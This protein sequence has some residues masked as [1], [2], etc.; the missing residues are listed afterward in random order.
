MSSARADRVSHPKDPTSLP[1]RA[2]GASHA[3]F[4]GRVGVLAA[5]LGVGTLIGGLGIAAADSGT[6][7]TTSAQSDSGT[8]AK[9]GAQTSGRGERRT[10]PAPVAPAAAAATERP[11]PAP[12]VTGSSTDTRASGDSRGS[13][14]RPGAV[15]SGRA[16]RPALPATGA[17]DLPRLPDIGR[18]VLTA[19]PTAPVA[20][21]D[22][23][24]VSAAPAGTPTPAAPEQVAVDAV[25]NP[26]L[27]GGPGAPG[28][29]A[30]AWA[31]L[32]AARRTGRVSAA[33]ATAQPLPAATTTTGTT[34]KITWAWGSNTALN[35][36]TAT[37]KLDFGWFAPTEFSVSENSGSTRISITNNNQTYTLTGVG[38]KQLSATTNIIALN[39][40]TAA[41]WQNAIATASS[42]ATSTPSTPTTPTSP[43]VSG[44]T[45][46]KIIWAWG[47]NTALNFNPATDKLDFGW[48][49][50]TN[51]EIAEPGGSTQISITGNNQT[52][53]L[54]GVGLKQMSTGNIIALDPATTAKWQNAITNAG[55]V[56]PPPVVS[57]PTVSIS[58]VSVAEGNSGSTTARF[59]VSLSK[60]ATST[61][62]VGYATANGTATAG[63]DYTATSGT[64]SFAPGV[65]SQQISVNVTGDTTV[66][67]DETF[68]VTLANP[69]GA[70][71][72][73]ASA[74][75][76]ITNDD[77]A[78]VVSA[79]TLSIANVSVA[80]GN[81]GSTTARFTVS[82]SKAATSTVTVGYA[83]AN[84]TATAGQDYTAA[85][86]TL[87]FTPGVISQQISVN[88]TGDT[89]V[90]PTETF[91]VTLTNPTGATF[92]S[93]AAT[94]SATGTITNDDTATTPVTPPVVG[95]RWGTTFYAPY[96]DMGGWPVP[97]LLAISQ[98]NGGG[99]LFTAAFMQATP[100][101]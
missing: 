6:D 51:F 44:G 77:T 32:A 5:A 23:P 30:L 27:G 99:S 13:D 82:L 87:S 49:Q 94:A 66:E 11:A 70:T 74:T 53:T 2:P 14:S 9:A 45:I 43:A 39:P 78:P 22:A 26:L 80:E 59:T 95:D 93:G 91:T 86:G 54:S 97:D 90:E 68:T 85:S 12:R 47:T 61:V 67:P 58:N 52:Y 41:K 62:T 35:F 31:V 16:V 21:G 17:A 92:V 72:A 101:G 84:G 15:T 25:V 71:L 88:V 83:T 38:L 50:P 55:T 36:N 96:V 42:T 56:T 76:T 33:S 48:F 18:P 46:T 81:S 10:A 69:T 65:I 8:N 64:V 63:Q 57:A 20:T 73:T 60:A 34:T 7:S 98:T 3:R 24:A 79:P 40:D 75:G 4:I 1:H 19:A 37:D 28:E 89:T 100:D 29:T